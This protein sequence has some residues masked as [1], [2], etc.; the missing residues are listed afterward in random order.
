MKQ[1]IDFEPAW[2]RRGFPGRHLFLFRAYAGHTGLDMATTQLLS[3]RL[4]LVTSR[5]G[6]IRY[7]ATS[8]SSQRKV[9]TPIQ[10]QNADK[11]RPL[12]SEAD[13]SSTQTPV[14]SRNPSNITAQIQPQSDPPNHGEIDR[15]VRERERRGRSDLLLYLTA[16]VMFVGLPP[17]VYWRWKY[18]KAHMDEKWERMK[19]EASLKHAKT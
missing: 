6:H 16:I 10:S 3:K 12:T 18:R 13:T 14:Q 4:C 11:L 8:E 5:L 15:H 2:H 1:L 17:L 7:Y 19:Q 9:Q